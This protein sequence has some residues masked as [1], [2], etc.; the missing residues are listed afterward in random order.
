MI[1][2]FILS[3]VR[4]RLTL[5]LLLA[6]TFVQAQTIYFVDGQ[7]GSDDNSGLSHSAPWK[8][9]Q[10][11]MNSVTPNSIV[12]IAG[13]TYHEN[14]I[15]NVNGLQG[16]P[17]LFTNYN[18]EEVIIDGT[19][20]SGTKLLQLI[21]K[22]HLFF[23][24]LIFQN[25]TVDGAKGI[26]VTTTTNGSST[27]LMFRDITVRNINWTD[28]PLAIALPSN[29]AHGIAVTGRTNGVT[30][31][32]IDGC[33]VYNNIL[34]YSEA[35]QING[36]VDNFSVTNCT[37][38]DNNNIGINITGNYGA[39]PIP[40]LDRP[41]N[42]LISR[43]VCY[44][45]IS[46][47]A[48][49]AGIYV[50]GGHDIIV[51][52]NSC[53]ENSIGIEVG[54]E[55][56]GI[57][58]YIKVR[59]N[60]MYNNLNSGLYVGGYTILTTGQVL[61]STFRNNTFFKNN[62][63]MVG[64]AE[65]VISKASNCV[66]EDNLLYTNEQNILL[67]AA[68]IWPQENNLI[69]YNCWFTPSGNPLGIVIYYGELSFSNFNTYKSVTGQESNSIFAN[70][71]FD[72]PSLPYPQLDLQTTSLCIDTGNP[73]L[74]ID[75]GETDFDGNPRISNGVVDMGAQEFDTTLGTSPLSALPGISMFPNP[76]KYQ[77]TISS[78]TPFENATFFLY[79]LSGR[80]VRTE[81]ISGKTHSVNR[82]ELASGIYAYKI[83]SNG[84]YLAGGKI[85]AE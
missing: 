79:D 77:I 48:L 32:I 18:N 26:E 72:D 12:M 6:H 61:Y 69:N 60:M 62:S 10:K 9:I 47:I 4:L 65:I 11:S 43:N 35:I 49:S 29:N 15:V 8:S 67:V 22:S 82:N 71:S 36:N 24:S 75:A 44:R 20:T 59:N 39:C 5:L 58:E 52:R 38:H 2:S 23:Q 54:C 56:D 40:T 78:P 76:F 30:N 19:G 74:T 28:N 53:Y 50:D 25:L 16:A 63:S 42:G 73:V 85:I 57:T 68:E 55:M 17:I 33:R 21:N 14:L 66:F 64:S 37:V 83:Q 34:G 51:E 27:N 7:N 13:G 3:K 1:G 80:I 84:S 45:N 81:N 31:I 46:P 70:P 41:R